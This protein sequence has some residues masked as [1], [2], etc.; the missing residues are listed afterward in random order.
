MF[1]DLLAGSVML[2]LLSAVAVK[3]DQ[4]PQGTD[5]EAGPVRVKVFAEGS[6]PIG[7]PL[8]VELQASRPAGLSDYWIGVECHPVS[9]VLCAQLGLAEGEGLVVDAVVPDSPAAVAGI[10]RHDVLIEAGGKSLSDITELIEAVDTAQDKELAI[11]LIR[12]GKKKQVTV[13][14]AKRPKEQF[15]AI[16][17][18]EQGDWQEWNKW[19]ER[20]RPGDIRVAPFQFE[21]IH[22]PAMLPPDAKVHPSMPGNM[23]VTISKQ[24]D[25]PAKI[26]VKKGDEKWEVTEEELDKLPDDVRPHIERMLGRIPEGATQLRRFEFVPDWI[27]PDRPEGRLR[28]RLELKVPAP[29]PLQER[30]EKRLEELNRQIEQLRKSIDDL[31]EK[32]SAPKTPEKNAE[33]I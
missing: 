17:L 28:E 18:P 26:V 10:R 8:A 33:E 29:G 19:F 1:R 14:P 23:S 16:P 15:P 30:M 6:E 9:P 25:A 31:R 20:L 5:A 27:R 32:G 11:A 7:G 12:A 21:F 22:P 4:P 24:G 2:A 3:A 13:T